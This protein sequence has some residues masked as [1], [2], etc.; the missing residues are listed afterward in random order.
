VESENQAALT[1]IN[2]YTTTWYVKIF[3]MTFRFENININYKGISPNA[4]Y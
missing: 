1:A 4:F 2:I 3:N